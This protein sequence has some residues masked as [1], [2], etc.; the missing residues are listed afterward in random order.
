MRYAINIFSGKQ[1]CGNGIFD[2]LGECMEFLEHDG[3]AD[4]AKILDSETGAQYT[5]KVKFD[6]VR[7][8]KK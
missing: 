5:I 4:K 2:T 3:F 1:F 8:A 7:E 6:E